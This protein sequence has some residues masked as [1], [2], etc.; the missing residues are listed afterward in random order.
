MI[1]ADGIPNPPAHALFEDGCSRGYRTADGLGMLVN[2]G[3][4]AIRSW[5]A[6]NADAAVMRRTLVELKL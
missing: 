2:Q 6:I 5:T 1:V 3:M 4:I